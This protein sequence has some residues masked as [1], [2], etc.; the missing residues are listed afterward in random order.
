M[1]LKCNLKVHESYILKK[2]CKV[3][4]SN[5]I[6]MYFFLLRR[7]YILY[8]SFYPLGYLTHHSVYSKLTVSSVQR[9]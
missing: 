8:F 4:L 6:S 1:R 5:L 7:K 2:Q 3:H 9:I